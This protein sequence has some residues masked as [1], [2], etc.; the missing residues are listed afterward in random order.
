MHTIVSGTER[1]GNLTT[2]IA[3]SL[4]RAIVGGEFDSRPFPIEA[5]IGEMFAASRSVT[6]EAVKMLTAKGLISSR[7]RL[8]TSVNPQENWNFLDPDVLR[9]MLDRDFSIALLAEFT[10]FRRSFE[11]RAALLACRNFTPGAHTP[12]FNALEQMARAGPMIDDTIEPDIAFHIAILD[13]SANR[14]MRQCRDLTATALRFSIRITDNPKA[15]Q[16][17]DVAAHG[18]IAEAIAARDEEAAL[19]FSTI[20]LEEAEARLASAMAGQGNQRQPQ[21]S[22]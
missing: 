3:D 11:P 21:M 2:Q 8:G 7:P 1:P 13:A 20:L 22:A 5:E 12:I 17:A 18:Y 14:F 6:R 9:W 19:H 16:G 4:G 10:A 15:V